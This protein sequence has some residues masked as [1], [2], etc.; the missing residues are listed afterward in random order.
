MCLGP[1]LRATHGCEVEVWAANTE[2]GAH[3]LSVPGCGWS[4]PDGV[5]ASSR[6]APLSPLVGQLVDKTPVGGVI[7]RRT[8]C[9][10]CGT[11][12]RGGRQRA[13]HH[14]SHLWNRY[15]GAAAINIGT[16][17]RSCMSTLVGHD[18]STGRSRAGGRRRTL[19]RLE[20]CS[21]LW[22]Q[23]VEH[24]ARH[25][26]VVRARGARAVRMS[27][28]TPHG[29]PRPARPSL[30]RQLHGALGLTLFF[31][32]HSHPSRTRRYSCYL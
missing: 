4:L 6:G 24:G 15:R 13:T 11:D 26:R 29:G 22:V 9:P 23:A 5:K 10:T 3:L 31:T 8:T 18:R 19:Y 12:T 7:A 1:R 14:L 25:Q 32:P 27:A 20:P 21:R 2:G 30:L 16:A 17:A 28:W